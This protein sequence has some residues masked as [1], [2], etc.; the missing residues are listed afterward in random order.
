MEQYE[1]LAAALNRAFEDLAIYARE[2]FLP[3]MQ[4]PMQTMNDALCAAYGDDWFERRQNGETL[5]PLPGYADLGWPTFA[6]IT[7]EPHD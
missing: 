3:A 4:L 1:Q 7:P 6:P 2:V 5:E